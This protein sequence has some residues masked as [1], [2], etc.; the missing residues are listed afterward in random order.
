MGIGPLMAWRRMSFKGLLKL[1]L[2][3]F[4]A[5][6]LLTLL[7]LIFD[8]SR[9][10]AAMAFGLS[11]FVAGGILGEFHRGLQSRREL[12][13]SSH[14][15]A[16]VGMIRQKPRRYGGQLVHLGVVVMAV[17][18]TAAFVYKTERDLELRV[19]DTV[20]IGRYQLELVSLDENRLPNYSA[21]IAQVRVWDS[22]GL[23]VITTLTPE[24]RFYY[25][26]DEV[27][28]EV[29]MRMTLREDLYLALAGLSG[30]NAGNN[31][32]ADEKVDLTQASAV[33]KVFIN[34]L[35]LWVWVGGLMMLSGTVIVLIPR[36]VESNATELQQAA[37]RGTPVRS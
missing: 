8:S 20:A 9:P 37:V 35:Q 31:G 34:P 29:D 12:V 15:A 36:L 33:M 1:A 32:S 28:T 4:L 18:M 21:L 2:K 30:I 24:R 16:I 14:G 6:S 26:N 19:G 27:T 7:F 17:S 22:R 13:R 3:P 5:G 11:F 10:L 25:R 23:A